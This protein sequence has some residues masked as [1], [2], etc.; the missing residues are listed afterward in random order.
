MTKGEIS[1][2]TG[3]PARTL[4]FYEDKGIIPEPVRGDNGY[5]N[6]DRSMVPRLK[7]I[8]NAQQLGFSLKEIRELSEMKISPDVSCESV[9]QKAMSKITDIDT[10]ISDLNSIKNA[11]T[12]FTKY[13]SPGK[14]I[15]ECEFIHLMEA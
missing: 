10:K 11:L 13:C 14:G 9:H 12:Q 15:E 7:F 3:I 1:A 4:R 6:Y 8:R 5:R 2:L